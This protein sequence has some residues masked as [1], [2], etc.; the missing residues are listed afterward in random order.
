MLHF[1]NIPIDLSVVLDININAGNDQRGEEPFE[2]E[3][4]RKHLISELENK[5]HNEYSD[6]KFEGNLIIES[7]YQFQSIPKIR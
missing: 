4:H 5:L 7:G 6:W 1:S 3:I 2:M